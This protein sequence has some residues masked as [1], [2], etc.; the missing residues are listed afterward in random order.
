MVKGIYS[1]IKKHNFPP[2]KDYER[3][4]KEIKTY[5]TSGRYWD[6]CPY[7]HGTGFTKGKE[8]S[9]LAFPPEKVCC[10]QCKGYGHRL[11]PEAER[12]H[13]EYCKQ[14]NEEQREARILRDKIEK[15]REEER[16]KISEEKWNKKRQVISDIKSAGR[17]VLKENEYL[18][19]LDILRDKR[20][21]LVR[22]IMS[23]IEKEPICTSCHIG[24]IRKDCSVCR[25]TGH[26][27]TIEA[28][29]LIDKVLELSKAIKQLWSD[30]RALYPQDED[31]GIRISSIVALTNLWSDTKRINPPKSALMRSRIVELLKEEPYC[32]HCLATGYLGVI[33]NEVTKKAYEQVICNRCNGSGK[34]YY[35]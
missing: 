31:A 35:N 26:I 9:Y 8:I 7:C 27:P 10:D 3:L 24:K 30:Y 21:E 22:K 25:G 16:K 29:K 18:S 4:N 17:S 23:D 34:L 15:E 5:Q 13:D 12:L 33:V 20:K 11:T 1:L 6:E 14:Y 2:R 19:Q 32:Q 28:N